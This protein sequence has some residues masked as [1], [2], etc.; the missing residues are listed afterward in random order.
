MLKSVGYNAAAQGAYFAVAAVTG[1]L[2]GRARRLERRRFARR[3][4]EQLLSRRWRSPISRARSGRRARAS[5]KRPRSTS[6]SLRSCAT[7]CGR[8]RTPI[9]PSRSTS[10]GRWPRPGC[11][12]RRASH[13]E[14]LKT[15]SAAADAEDKTEKQPVTPGPLA[16]ARELYGAMLLERG[17]AKEALAA[18]EATLKKEP[19]RFGATIGAARGGAQGGRRGQGAD[20]LRGGGGACCRR[21]SGAAPRLRKRVLTWRR[22]AGFRISG[23]RRACSLSRA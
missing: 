10:S 15:M 3:A 14:A 6:P 20:A 11:C 19:H 22:H 18:F 12:L 7:S 9:G 2:H 4:A 8:R 17:M 23:E 5:P 16:P 13:D 1:A 21:R